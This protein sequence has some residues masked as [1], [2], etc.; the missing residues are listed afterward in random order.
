MT[1][2]ANS[3]SVH[4]SAT[5]HVQLPGSERKTRPKY[6]LEGPA[7]PDEVIR[8]VMKVRPKELVPDPA[9]IGAM[10]P[11][12]RP[13]PPSREEYAQKYGSDPADID[14]V[15]AFAKAHGFE[16]VEA[17]PAQR[18]VVLKGTVKQASAAFGTELHM[19][20]SRETGERYRGRVGQIQIP[21]ELQG[22]VTVVT[23]LDNRRLAKKSGI[24]DA[25]GH[26]GQGSRSDH[27]DIVL[28]HATGPVLQL[29]DDP[30]RDRP[31]HRD[32]RIRGRIRHERPFHLLRGDSRDRADRD[33]DL[34]RTGPRMIPA[35]RT[36]R[37][38]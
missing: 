4:P 38:R 22:I 26:R 14:K 25:G 33:G 27:S 20:R 23:G 6:A 9:K 2:H 17:E 36:P 32:P 13:A 29:P 8:V 3:A 31:V 5:R 34:G 19:Y 21:A 35:T 30:G 24:R 7:H 11:T 28:P 15:V 37:P 10:L 12:Q 1:Q 16:V 18:M